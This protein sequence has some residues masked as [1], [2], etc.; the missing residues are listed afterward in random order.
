MRTV[1][2]VGTSLAGLRAVETLRREG[3]DGRDRRDRRRA[4]PAR[5]TGRRCR[6]SCSPATGRARRDRAAQ[7]GRRRPRPRL[8]ARA[9]AR[10]RS[11]LADAHGR[12]SHD[13]E[14]VAFD[15]L[16]HRDRLDA[17]PAAGPARPR[18]RVHAAHARRRARAPRP[19]STRG[20][21]VVVIGAGFIGAEVAATCRGR[22][23]DVT[24]LEALPQPM[25]RGLGPELG[26]VIA[27]VHRDHGVDLRPGVSVEA[28]EGDGARRAGAARRRRRRS[29]PTS[30]WSASASCPRPTGS[31]ARASRS[32]TAS[33][34]TRRCSPRPA[35]S[36]PATSR[37]GRTRCS[38]AS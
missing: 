16:V 1:A 34:A 19:R 17:A 22:G 30:W 3:F 32:T 8:A 25:V 4:A 2:V 35:S 27:D 24:V 10:P 26:A 15:G 20:P 37:A 12:R 18:R 7:A 14:R 28:I 9:R 38:T 5:T 36:P 23:L 11:T 29:R 33:C 6:R 21:K 31:K 13:G